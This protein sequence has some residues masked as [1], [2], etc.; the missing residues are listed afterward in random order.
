MLFFSVQT[1]KKEE[2]ID[3]TATVR[4]LVKSSGIKKSW[5]VFSFRIPPAD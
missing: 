4:D 3:L 5:L 1:S 2:F